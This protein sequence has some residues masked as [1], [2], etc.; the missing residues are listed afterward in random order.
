MASATETPR[1]HDMEKDTSL[2]LKGNI[3][4]KLQKHS[5][6]ADAAM[7][8]F[9]GM[10]GQVIELTEEKSRALLKKIDRH[11]M[12]I[13]C[14]VYGL[15]YLDKTTLSYAS[16][17]G[18]RSPPSDNKLK[19]GIDLQGDQYQWLGS[20]FYFG[21]IAWEY[22]TTR[23]LQV[24]PLGKY[25]AFN[26]IMWGIV[27]SCF[28]AVENYAG[29]IAI[30]FF[31]GLF[32]S[33]VTPGFALFTSQ[34]YTKKEQGAR[35]GIWFSFNGF[36]QIFGGCLAYGIA[37][38]CRK[39]GTTI[40]PWKIVFLATGLLTTLCGILFLW[41]VPDNQM[42]C[43]WLS[44]EDRI[45]AIERIRMNGQG[46]GNKHFKFYQL[47]EA[48]LDPL[49]WAFF[50]YALIAAIPNGGIS[51]FFSQLIVS[52]GYTPEESLLYGTPGGAV[53]VVFLIACGWAGDK[54]GYRILISTTGLCT[55]ILGMVLIVALPLDNNSGRLAGYYLTQ[56]SPTPFVALL[57]LI[58]SNVAGYTKKTTVAA[59]YLIGYCV[60]NI[61]GPQTFRPK[62]A[63]RYVPAEITI[64]VSWSVCLGILAFIHCYCVWQNKKKAQI[65]AA[66]E[67][68]HIPNQEWLDL[69]DRENPEFVYTL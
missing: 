19:S 66:P 18:L 42:N 62:D 33:A 61:I 49:S 31:L 53:E 1:S 55:G 30:R 27:L 32:E 7:Q 3:G 56:A 41:I 63:P 35:T 45:L 10:D 13:M 5:H 17:M 37:V 68:V 64:I 69:T 58:S 54:Y 14:I 38:G 29:A 16:I 60:G 12:P 20:M 26:I 8:A 24:L 21:Y 48:L 59:M 52:F 23:L 25:S 34:W 47:K 28:A 40:E 39:T 50:F 46:V 44:K 9:D 15:N 11:L 4:E 6:D 43:R 57:S 2:G 22:P 36:A 65:R 67:Y 51:N